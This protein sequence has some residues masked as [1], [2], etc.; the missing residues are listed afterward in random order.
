MGIEVAAQMTPAPDLAEAQRMA[1]Q[2]EAPRCA[3][4]ERSECVLDRR[5]APREGSFARPMEPAGASL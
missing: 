4:E 3:R 2:V 5:A 1:R